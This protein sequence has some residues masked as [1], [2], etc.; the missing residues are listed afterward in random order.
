MPYVYRTLTYLRIKYI[1]LTHDPTIPALRN[2]E[3]KEWTLQRNNL[4][5]TDLL[6]VLMYTFF[7]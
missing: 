6:E 1:F 3:D 5:Q 7:S 4:N 2:P